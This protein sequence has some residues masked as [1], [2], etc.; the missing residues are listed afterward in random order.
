VCGH[1]TGRHRPPDELGIP[2]VAWVDGKL[3]ITYFV[4][5]FVYIK[6]AIENLTDLNDS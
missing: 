5:N 3:C 2:V 4:P 1:V 6:L